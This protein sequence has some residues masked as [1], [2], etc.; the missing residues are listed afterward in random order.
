MPHDGIRLII[1]NLVELLKHAHDNVS[2]L[3]QGELLTQSNPWTSVERQEL[4]AR[5]SSDPAFGLEFS[6]I[7][8]PDILPVMHDVDRIGHLCSLGYIQRRIAVWT[9]ASRDSRVLGCSSTIYGNRS[10]VTKDLVHGVL[11]IRAALECF[12]ADFLGI[13]VRAE[14]LNDG[15]TQ[16]LEDIWMPD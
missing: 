15:V 13:L 7:R 12:E 1:L 11:Q 4:P 10:I 16:F 5:L 3:R 8:T 2:G 6:N 14:L 9:P